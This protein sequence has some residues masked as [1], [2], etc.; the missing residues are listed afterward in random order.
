MLRLSRI[1]VRK[2]AD[3]IARKRNNEKIFSSC[4]CMQYT[5]TQGSIISNFVSFAA[6][7]SPTNMMAQAPSAAKMI[8]QADAPA[9]HQVQEGL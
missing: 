5:L 8:P 2:D 6:S 4:R 3:G 1:I 9:R 7:S